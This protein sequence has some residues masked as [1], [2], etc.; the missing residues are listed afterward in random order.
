MTFRPETFCRKKKAITQNSS[1]LLN[2][3]P[4]TDFH[5]ICPQK[6]GKWIPKKKTNTQNSLTQSPPTLGF[7]WIRPQK[8]WKWIPKF[9]DELV[10]IDHLLQPF[11]HAWLKKFSTKENA[12][13]QKHGQFKRHYA[14]LKRVSWMFLYLVESNSSCIGTGEESLCDIFHRL[15]EQNGERIRQNC[16]N[17]KTDTVDCCNSKDNLYC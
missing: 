9:I 14:L 17:N 7:H 3:P 15:N 6:K 8:K 13:W 11:L 12:E 10:K 2:S 1:A 4:P 16:N 5:W